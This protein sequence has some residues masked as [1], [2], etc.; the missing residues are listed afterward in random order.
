MLMEPGLTVETK[1]ASPWEVSAGTWLTAGGAATTF[2]PTASA[3][4]NR[5]QRTT[6]NPTASKTFA[7]S[8]VRR[9]SRNFFAASGCLPDF[10]T[11]AG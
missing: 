3:Q 1:R 7:H 8:G 5:D 2:A 4:Q 11:A 6:V 10:I 9:N